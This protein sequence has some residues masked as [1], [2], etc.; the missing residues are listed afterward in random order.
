MENGVCGPHGL[1]AVQVAFNLDIETVIILSLPMEDDTVLRAKGQEGG[2]PVGPDL[3]EKIKKRT[4]KEIE[5]EKGKENLYL[6]ENKKKRTEKEIAKEIGNLWSMIW[7]ADTVLVAC[8]NV[9]F[10][11]NK[12]LNNSILKLKQ[13]FRFLKD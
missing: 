5:I 7:P 10:I 12:S 8:V 13:F 4:E 11:L 3:K 1:P 6:K 9:S 2:V